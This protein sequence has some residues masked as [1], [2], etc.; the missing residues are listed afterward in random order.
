[1]PND[2][3]EPNKL[4]AIIRNGAADQFAAVVRDQEKSVSAK[5]CILCALN[6]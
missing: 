3:I 5:E 2:D 6:S 4:P 1:M